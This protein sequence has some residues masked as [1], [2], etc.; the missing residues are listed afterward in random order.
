MTHGEAR[1]SGERQRSPR[2]LPVSEARKAA[3]DRRRGPDWGLR[4]RP[5]VPPGKFCSGL[6]GHPGR[7]RPLP[8]VQGS[9]PRQA[10]QTPQQ[11]SA[12]A[13]PPWDRS[14]CCSAHGDRG[15]G[16]AFLFGRP[17][18]PATSEA[19]PPTSRPVPRPAPDGP[20]YFPPSPPPAS[21]PAR[22]PAPRHASPRPRPLP[23]GTRG[24]S[25]AHSCVARHRP[26]R[27]VAGRGLCGYGARRRSPGGDPRSAE[28]RLLPRRAAER[29][30]R[31]P[32]QPGRWAPRQRA[33]R[34]HLRPHSGPRPPP[35]CWS[36]K[37]GPASGLGVWRP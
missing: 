9:V 35:Q 11:T 5:A 6:G 16:P 34:P 7:R 21:R 31:C 24:L 22:P 30:R 23:R 36:E 2:R 25:R 1:G 3:A 29:G 19:T 13:R 10:L 28:G 33:A 37:P 27:C 15:R 17:G 20:A 14:P 8:A 32:A 12:H 4:P 26:L 18:P